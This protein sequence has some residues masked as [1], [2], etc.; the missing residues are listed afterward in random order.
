MF[1]TH[2]ATADRVVRLR[3]GSWRGGTMQGGPIS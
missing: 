2:P 1:S 3:E